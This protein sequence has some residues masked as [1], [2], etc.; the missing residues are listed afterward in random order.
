MPK[1]FIRQEKFNND[2]FPSKHDKIGRSSLFL[3]LR[4]G[5]FLFF[6]SLWVILGLLSGLY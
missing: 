3:F 1:A 6:E 4:F 2:D 5:L